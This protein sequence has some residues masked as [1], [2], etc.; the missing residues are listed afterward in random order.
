M[1]LEITWGI[2]VKDKAEELVKKKINNDDKN[3]TPFEKL[4]KKKKEKKKQKKLKN[5]QKE[6]DNEES[7]SDEGS[8][9]E[10]PSDIDMNDPYFAEEFN[11]TEFKKSSNKKKQDN[12]NTSDVDSEDEKRKAELE[13]LL[14]EDDGKAHFS[15][16]KIQEG[17][18]E[19]KKSKRKR[20]LKAKM[21][22]QRQALPDFEINVNDERFSALYDSHHY[23]IDP[24]DPNFKKTKNMEKLI[25]EKLKRRPSDTPVQNQVQSKKSKE[26]AEL[27][28]LVKNIKRKIKDV[29]K[30]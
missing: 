12:K 18:S 7:G 17:E 19:S 14:D 8:E 2:G 5:K 16:K 23:N 30:K 24:S 4:L 29:I 27:S 21:M 13:L 6:N 22:E 10:I 9:D 25:K 11:K 1:E 28:L 20:K 15:L 3:L 26:E